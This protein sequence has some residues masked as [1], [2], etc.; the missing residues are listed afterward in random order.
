[1]DCY[2]LTMCVPPAIHQAASHLQALPATGIHV[3]RLLA[4]SAACIVAGGAL[5]YLESRRYR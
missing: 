4:L 3:L 1:M 5:F 2:P